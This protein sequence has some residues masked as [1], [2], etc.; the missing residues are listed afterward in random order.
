MF[1][2]GYTAFWQTSIELPINFE[3]SVIDPDNKRAN[4]SDVLLKAN[5]PRL[6]QDALAVKLGVDPDDRSRLA[7]LAG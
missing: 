6:A 5:Y 3:E 1:S 4:N 2:N 7:T